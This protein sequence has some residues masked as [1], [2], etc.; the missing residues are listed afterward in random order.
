MSI[1]S[2]AAEIT[3]LTGLVRD[4]INTHRYQSELLDNPNTWNQICSSLDVIGDSI[5][6]VESYDSQEFP[7]DVGLKYIYTYGILQSL[8]L[9]QDALKHLSEAFNISYKP[10]EALKTIR[11]ARNASIG[12][13]TK[14]IRGER[15]Y[16]N[17]ISRVSMGK[18]GFE[19]LRSSEDREISFTH[20]DIEKACS[21]QLEGIIGAY[22]K[23]AAKLEE[24]D[25][26]HKEKFKG[27]RMT[28]ILHSAMSYLFEK[29]SEG[30]HASSYGH[31]EFGHLQICSV[32]DTYEKFRTALEDRN[33][34]ND[35][36]EF[37]LDEYFH[38]IGRLEKF[39]SGE[40]TPMQET[41]AHIYLSYLRYRH[42]HFVRIAN[43][44]DEEYERLT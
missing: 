32:K 9:M 41:D 34:L 2:L 13:P 24:I 37:D 36:V 35:Y 4:H 25:K 15:R 42:D 8:Y 6:A 18:S 26:V 44:I 1:N 40:G 33:E 16:Y 38:A 12:H 31:R 23:I 11:N 20:I 27:M 39:L 3:R 19:L 29:I 28:D 22:G 10:T 21:D 43:E 14:E 5:L 7:D 17:F 30:I